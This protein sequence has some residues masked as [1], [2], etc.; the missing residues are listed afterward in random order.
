ME[1]RSNG[2]IL[3]SGEYFI[4]D[5]AKAIGIPCKKGQKII[6]NKSKNENF[7]TW[8]SYDNNKALW[9]KSKFD[10]KTF[11]IR[12]FFDPA[13]PKNPIFTGVTRIGLGFFPPIIF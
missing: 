1:F 12:P 2:K 11:G 8:E 7:I 4:I 3:L 6:I 13:D 10:I 5:G 9:F